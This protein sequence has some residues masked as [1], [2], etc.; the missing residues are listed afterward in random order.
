[1]ISSLLYLTANRPDIMHNVCMCVRFQSCPKES[2][3]TTVKR[4]MKYLKGTK[5][6]RLWYLRG[7]NISLTRYSD[8]DFGGCKLNRKSTS[9]TCHLLGCSLIT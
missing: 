3:L 1:M 5:T 7:A 8:S 4:I 6:L 2:H 9:D